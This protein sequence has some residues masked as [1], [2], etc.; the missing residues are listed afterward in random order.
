MTTK[1]YHVICE[2]LRELIEETPWEG[3]LFAVGG[4]CRDEILGLE[5]SDLDLAVDLPMEE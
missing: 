4:C 1:L 2:W 3:H 5:I